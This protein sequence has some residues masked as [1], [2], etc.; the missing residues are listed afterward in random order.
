MNKEVKDLLSSMPGITPALFDMLDIE[1]EKFD[2][3]YPFIMQTLIR[4]FEKPDFQQEMYSIIK[5]IPDSEYEHEVD[6]YKHIINTVKGDSDL[7]ENKKTY[8]LFTFEKTLEAFKKLWIYRVP[9][10]SVKVYKMTPDA[11]LPE[12]AH[13]TDAG[14]DITSIETITINGGETKVVKTGLMV[15]IP[16]G[17]EIQIRPRSGMSLKTPLRI[18]NCVGTI[19]ANY[20][21]EVGVIMHNTSNEPYTIEKGTKIAQ[22]FVR[23]APRIDWIVV[24]S[25][26]ELGDTDRGKGGYGSTGQ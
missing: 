13:P 8:L 14:A 5:T 9:Y 1:D 11:I 2:A 10:T 22:M 25:E 17:Y 26:E 15:G 16:V 19:D 24:Q 21:G 23:P 7:S 20:R 3:V 4:T 6:Q 18:A 12:P